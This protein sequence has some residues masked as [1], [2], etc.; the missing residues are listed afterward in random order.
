M[1]QFPVVWLNVNGLGDVA[2]IQRIGDI[3]GL[4][5]LALEDAVNVHQR[6]KL[7]TF[8]GSLFLVAR[9]ANPGTVLDL[10]QLS[11]FIGKNFLIT[12]QEKAGDCFEGVRDRLRKSLGNLRRQG[13]DF[14]AYCLMDSV[15]DSYFPMLER[16]G[17]RL[18]GI[19][20]R[21]LETCRPGDLHELHAIKRELF[22][23]RRAVWPLR[24]SLNS[25]M[26]EPTDLITAE[27]R[28]HWRDCY[29]HAVQII[30]L[31]ETYRELGSDLMDLS[32]SSMN[33][34]M[35]EV[36]RVLTIIATIF[37]PMTFVASIY[38]MNF[39]FMPELHW[40]Y[41]YLLA[42]SIMGV[43]ALVMLVWF[44]RKGWLRSFTIAT[45]RDKRPS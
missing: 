37:I 31:L 7:D 40:R 15:I 39:E 32:L 16:Y 8:P 19:E 35:N 30:E 38:G 10:E 22:H 6:S 9:I 44:W 12:F 24:D 2:L 25:L 18:E 28:L 41:G 23:L 45:S 13:P 42:L 11:F 27:T 34:R 14:L 17:E 43:V 5:P 26:R 29:D 4:H 33:N 36:M 20:D 3:F 21:A 1:G